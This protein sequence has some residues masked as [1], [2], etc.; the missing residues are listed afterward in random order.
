MS[1]SMSLRR[2]VAC[3]IG[4]AL[5]L[6]GCGGGV[7]VEDTGPRLASIQARPGEMIDISSHAP[8][9]TSA[10]LRFTADGF[11]ASAT[12]PI[13]GGKYVVVPVVPRAAAETQSS[14]SLAPGSRTGGADSR[15][16][17]LRAVLS[18]KAGSRT[19]ATANL[20]V[21]PHQITTSTPGV[22]STI[23]IDASLQNAQSAY[24]ELVAIGESES[25]PVAV[26][27]RQ[28]ITTLLNV[29]QAVADAMAGKPQVLY[30]AQGARVVVDEQALAVLDQLV[31]GM[32]A[33]GSRLMAASASEAP[34][35]P[36]EGLLFRARAQA[37]AP[38]ASDPPL[39]SLPETTQRARPQSALS[40]PALSCSA[41]AAAEDRAWCENMRTQ[42]G[43]DPSIAYGGSGSTVAGFALGALTSVGAV[44]G[45]T[46]LLAAGTLA[47]FVTTVNLVAG[48]VQGASAYGSGTIKG[49]NVTENIRNIREAVASFVGST[50][51]DLSPGSSELLRQL[52]GAVLELALERYIDDVVAL[53]RQKTESVVACT[54]SSTSGGPGT[55]A[56]VY[57]FGAPR[58]VVLDYDSFG[59]PDALDVYDGSGSKISTAGLVNGK[60]T[61]R[62][63]A[64][65]RTVTVKVRSPEE[66]SAWTYSLGCAS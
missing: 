46:G 1:A 29:R 28:H 47:G 52:R 50:A 10:T 44:S 4:L 26:Q 25:I 55:F 53:I 33:S 37:L 27:M 36:L 18:I 2:Q 41:L 58:T 56:R 64:K 48:S 12:L 54:A 38:P 23:Y 7:D 8:S 24:Q 14:A 62:F 51:N 59:I 43:S 17:G 3:A 16:P 45:P 60:G 30:E 9:A 22:A 66:G 5:A 39:S 15:D 57:D 63:A 65:T 19:V 42:I 6:A 34:A 20:T 49:T 13:I 21:T 31:T 61:L 40:V 35:K 11:P 32:L